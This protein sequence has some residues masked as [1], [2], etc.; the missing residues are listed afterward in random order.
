MSSNTL[1]AP[2]GV[3]VSVLELLD[4]VTEVL[5]TAAE[6]PMGRVPEA[7]LGPLL[8]RLSR[9]ESRA[10]SLKGEVLA[11]A[12]RRQ[13]ALREAA[14]GTDAWATAFTGDTRELNAGGLRIARLLQSTY[15]RTREAFAAGELTKQQVR[16]IVDALEQT[17]LA[18]AAGSGEEEGRPVATRE[19]LAA[20]EDLAV[21]KATGASRRN[22]RPMDPKRLR[23]AMRRI[24]DRVDSRLADR[25]EAILLGRESRHARHETY[26]KLSDNGDGTW[27][28][29]FTVPELHGRLLS[30]VLERLTAPRR[31][32]TGSFGQPVV[33]EAATNGDNWTLSGWEKQG[34]AFC[35]L[36]EHLPTTGWSLTGGGNA[37]TVLVRVNLDDLMRRVSDQLE[38]VGV[39]RLDQ[40]VAFSAADV[41]R[42]ACEAEVVPTILDG[43]EAVMYH[44]RGRRLHDRHQRNALAH[45]HDSCAISGCERPFAWTEVHHTNPWS[46]GGLTDIDNG[47]PLCGW[48]HQRA[49]DPGFRLVRNP[50]DGPLAWRLLRT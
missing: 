23:Q 29:R 46:L 7:D 22:G 31:H 45:L 48:H 6:R 14:T 25:H 10:A 38:E 17:P 12:E 1:L 40:G 49:H 28:G 5:G 4:A 32:G 9:I 47:I 18:G 8:S 11:E 33:D 41:Q 20:G 16:V 24:Y 21:A 36:L 26:L 34:Q 50:D 37:T 15:H 13:T 39:G 43:D 30:G 42:L 44:G 19:Q 35:E 27:S 3:D 2:L